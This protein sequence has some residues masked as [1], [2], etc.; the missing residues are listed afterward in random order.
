MNS[1]FPNKWSFSYYNCKQ[2]QLPFF[3]LFSISN[4]KKNK[5]GSIM[6]N[7]YSID[8]IAEDH[9]HT[10]TYRRCNMEEPQQKYRLGMVINQLLQLCKARTAWSESDQA[11]QAVHSCNSWRLGPLWSNSVIKLVSVLFG[12]CTTLVATKC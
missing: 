6:G 4:Y 7:C 5:T 3:Y 2:Q 1:S 11:V 9:I 12:K 8:H 10:S